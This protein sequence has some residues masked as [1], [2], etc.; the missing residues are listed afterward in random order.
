MCGEPTGT[1]RFKTG[2]YTL[3]DMPREFQKAT[4]CIIQGLE[5]VICYLDDILVATKAGIEDHNDLVDKVMQRLN[6]EG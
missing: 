4:D 5:G 6:E 1:Y 3:T 2:F